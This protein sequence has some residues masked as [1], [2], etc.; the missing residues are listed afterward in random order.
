VASTTV[1]ATTG[2]AGDFGITVARPLMAVSVGVSAFG[3]VRSF[4][5]GPIPEIKTDACLALA[6]FPATVTAP[7]VDCHLVLSE[8]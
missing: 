4:V 3:A 1:L 6:W 7:V 2:T 8:R 5:D